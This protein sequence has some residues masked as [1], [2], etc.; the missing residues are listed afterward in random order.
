MLVS[1]HKYD[2]LEQELEV[3][4]KELE[5]VEKECQKFRVES[6]RLDKA[7]LRNIVPY[8]EIV[9]G[10]WV[11]SSERLLHKVVKIRDN[12]VLD[13]I[14][15][16]V[17]FNV[18]VVEGLWDSF[19]EGPICKEDLIRWMR[20]NNYYRGRII[21]DGFRSKE[22]YEYCMRKFNGKLPQ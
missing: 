20:N 9:E 14:P 18:Q 8:D 2:K 12:W 7:T 15:N 16:R 17:D 19:K 1:K 6:S 22:G 4:K 11:M 5:K 10:S 13:V 21:H 3:C